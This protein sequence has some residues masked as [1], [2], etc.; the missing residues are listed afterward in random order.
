MTRDR[1]YWVCSL[2][3]G[4]VQVGM[5]TTPQNQNI[6]LH[7]VAPGSRGVGIWYKGFEA[8]E[9]FESKCGYADAFGHGV[10]PER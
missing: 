5:I 3:T 2:V 9:S 4:G 10:S 8:E 6:D 7:V 1:G